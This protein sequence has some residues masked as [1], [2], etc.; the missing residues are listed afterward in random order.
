MSEDITIIKSVT[1]SEHRFTQDETYI[2]KSEEPSEPKL[3]L[4]ILNIES[5]KV[6]NLVG[7]EKKIVAFVDPIFFPFLFQSLTEIVLFYSRIRNR[8]IKLYIYTLRDFFG[9]DGKEHWQKIKDFFTHYLIDVGVDFEFLDTS[10][11]DAIK[12]NNFLI[13]QKGFSPIGIKVLSSRVKKYLPESNIKPFRK[14]FVARKDYLDQ[15]IDDT[16]RVHE[17]FIN[18]GFEIVYPESFETFLEQV[19]Y[20]SECRVIA[21]VS[22]SGLSNCIFMKPGGSMIE[23]SSIFRPNSDSYPVEVHHYYRIMANVMKHLYLSISNFS[24]KSDDFINNKRHL[25]IIK[26]L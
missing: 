12:I 24:A 25:D 11:F 20:F 17:F 14:V 21:G 15:R 22:G 1:F 16:N 8:N 5:K 9:K 18:A 13:I 4:N 23:L 10:N 19:N 3:V 26:M 7:N 6:L 2:E